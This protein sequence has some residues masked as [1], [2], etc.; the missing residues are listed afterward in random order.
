[1]Y[2]NNENVKRVDRLTEN[3]S[4]FGNLIGRRKCVMKSMNSISV[5][6][7]H[8]DVYKRQTTTTARPSPPWLMTSQPSVWS[9]AKPVTLRP[10]PPPLPP[11]HQFS[12]LPTTAPPP[13]QQS[14]PPPL[15]PLPPIEDSDIPSEESDVEQPSPETTTVT[16]TAPSTARVS[17]STTGT[18]LFIM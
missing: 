14:Q 17:L 11:I 13:T 4:L 12:P 7:T 10:G 3:T 9:T 5:S 18:Y 2:R 1:M 15:H 8:L 16:S 6:Y